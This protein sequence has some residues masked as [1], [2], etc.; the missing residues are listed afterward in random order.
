MEFKSKYMDFVTCPYFGKKYAM[1]VKVSML[2]DIKKLKEKGLITNACFIYSM[3]DGYIEKE[4]KIKEFINEIESMGI[5]FKELHTSGH[6]DTISM[7]K[8]NEITNPEKTI[9]IHTEYKNNAKN[10]FNNIIDLDDNEIFKL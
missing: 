6:S 9:V 7:K 10:I 2:K 1:N 3:W 5:E 4:E 8:L